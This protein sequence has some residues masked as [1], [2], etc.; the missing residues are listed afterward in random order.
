VTGSPEVVKLLT[1]D[2]ARLTGG[3]IAVG[4]D[5]AQVVDGIE[6]HIRNKRTA[7]GI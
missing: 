1:E 3:R 7:L 5:P 6:A 2:V 4:D